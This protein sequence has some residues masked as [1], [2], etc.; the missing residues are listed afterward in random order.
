MLLLSFIEHVS[1]LLSSVPIEKLIGFIIMGAV[2]LYLLYISIRKKKDIWE[3]IKGKDGILE[4]PEI[5]ITICMILYPVIVLAD[6]FLGLHASEAIFW[7]LDAIIFFAL[8]GRVAMDKFRQEKLQ[9]DKNEPE[10]P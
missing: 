4:L 5:I 6:V 7:S 1:T 10:Q 2:L 9:K 3:G 8:T